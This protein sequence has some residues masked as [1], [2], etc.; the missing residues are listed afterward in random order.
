M[1]EQ[2]FPQPPSEGNGK[3]PFQKSF[4]KCPACQSE[5]RIGENLIQEQKQKRKLHKDS[6]PDGL[7]WQVPL[8][9]ETRPPTIL[10]TNFT[11]KIALIY[12]DVCADCGMIYC[13]KFS[14]VDA[15][16]QLQRPQQP[17]RN[18]LS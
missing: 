2:L 8:F 4:T 15:P 16:A 9:D 12:W 10:A 1:S 7:V 17:P 11:V 14:T 5:K 18:N 13:T 6:F 3:N